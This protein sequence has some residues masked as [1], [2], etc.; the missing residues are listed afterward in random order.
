MKRIALLPHVVVLFGLGGQGAPAAAQ[1][2]PARPIRFVVGF[3]AGGPTDRPARFIADKLSDMLGKPVIVENKPGAASMIAIRDVLSRPRDGYSL[4]VCTYFDPV[5]P[6]LYRSA[7]YGISDIEP[8]TLIAKYDY[9][10]ALAN[11][12]P[13][14]NMQ[15][16]IA[17][18]KQNPDKLNYGHLGVGFDENTLAKKLEKMTGMKMTRIP[19]KG[20]ADA[21]QEDSIRRTQSSVHRAADRGDAALRGPEAQGHCG[22]RGGTAVVGARHPDAQGK[23][24][25]VRRLRV[26]RHLRRIRNAETDRRSAQQPDRHDRS[27]PEYRALVEKSGSVAVSSTPQEFKAEIDKT[28]SDAA[29]IIQEFGLQTD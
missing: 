25:S 9:A 27:S 26:A 5:N 17:Y 1:D 2:Y 13:A 24:D 20:A 3:T 21:V 16:L 22:D 28:V 11:D 29:P 8:V 18:A 6:L 23:R 4:S 12:I 14:R 19:Y 7:G 15:E 10:I